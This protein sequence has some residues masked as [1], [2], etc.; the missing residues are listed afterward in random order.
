MIEHISLRCSDSK[1]SRRFYQRALAPLG[2]ALSKKYGD[3]FGFRQGGRHDFWVTQ[4]EVATP[5]HVAFTAADHRGVE[6]FYRAAL[7]AG[8][9]DN[10]PPGDRKGYG[11]AAFVLDP[12]GHN[13]EAVCFDEL[14]DKETLEDVQKRRIRSARSKGRATRTAAKRSK[15]PARRR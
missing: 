13:V 8:G 1:A 6:E 11:F 12:D 10:G 2:Y 9:K 14:G 3:S 4:G 7:K 5:N 15:R